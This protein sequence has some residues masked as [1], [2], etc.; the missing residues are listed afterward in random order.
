M[1]SG[2][3]KQIDT[4]A[5]HVTGKCLSGDELVIGR[6]P[7][8]PITH[9]VLMLVLIPDNQ[10]EELVFQRIQNKALDRVFRHKMR[11]ARQWRNELTLFALKRVRFY[12]DMFSEILRE[13]KPEQKP[14]ATEAGEPD[15]L[16]EAPD[17]VLAE[18]PAELN[19]VPFNEAVCDMQEILRELVSALQLD[20]VPINGKYKPPH[21]NYKGFVMWIVDNNYDDYLTAKNFLTYIHC[22]RK[23]ESIRRYYREAEEKQETKKLIEKEKNREIRQNGPIRY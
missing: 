6:L 13:I 7:D 3:G 21:E 8:M 11:L 14:Q 9:F 16:S 20:P 19:V 12:E 18:Q 2:N 1:D 15:I 4:E 17:P 10:M 5:C 22:P 23:E